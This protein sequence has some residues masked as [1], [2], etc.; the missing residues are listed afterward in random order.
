MLSSRRTLSLVVLLCGASSG[1]VAQHENHDHNHEPATLSAVDVGTVEFA[2]SCKPAVKETFDRGVSLLHSFWF[3]RS[4]TTFEEVLKADPDCAIAYWGIALTH[5]GNPFAGLRTPATI[6]T[7][8]KSTDLAQS[9]GK[10]TARERGYI[11]AVA[12]LFS[13]REVGTQ[14]ER[15]VA[16]ETAMKKLAAANPSDTEA[17]IFAALAIAQAALPDDKTYSRQLEAG[18]ILEPLFARMPK[19]PGLAHYIIHSYDVPPL[20]GKALPA[21]QSYADIAPAVAHALHMPSHTF[22][23]VGMWKESVATNIRSA[24]NAERE[25]EP[26]A[27]LHALDYMTYAYLQMGMDS[28]ANDAIKW[29]GRTVSGIKDKSAADTIAGTFPAVAMPARY[30]LEREQWAQAAQLPV[31]AASAPYV[32]AMVRFARAL[33]AA[34]SGKLDAVPAELERLEALRKKSLDMKDAYWASIIDIQRQGAT[35]WYLFEQGKRSEALAAMRAA[36]NAEDATEKSV[37]TPGPLAPARE[38]LGFMLLEAN[39]PEEALRAFD[40]AIVKEP[41]RFLSLYGAGKAAEAANRQAQAKQYY[42][43]IVD[44]CA[45]AKPERSELIYARKMAKS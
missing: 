25:S 11:D 20:A 2:T 4:R 17:Q 12:I 1:A 6:D 7:G 13:N 44:I 27:V 9:T 5:W 30:V 28:Q 32:E 36:A 3:A 42:A 43:K 23:R 40:A 19:H 16:Y 31:P 34:R 35:A 38:L 14:R 45:D 21:A 33:G 41:N 15:T 8:K 10:P 22:T 39:R 29:L 26:G 24:E 18:A 37:V